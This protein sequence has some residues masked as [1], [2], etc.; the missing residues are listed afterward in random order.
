MR[1]KHIDMIQASNVTEKVFINSSSLARV[2]IRGYVLTCAAGLRVIFHRP[3]RVTADLRSQMNTDWSVQRLV[4]F[5]YIHS[6][7]CFLILI[8]A[9][10]NIP[11]LKL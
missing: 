6:D 2:L 3:S 10:R 11:L 5:A 9:M 4:S 7:L 1:H 8:T